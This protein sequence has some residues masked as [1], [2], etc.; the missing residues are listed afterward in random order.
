[1]L[2]P[3][4][5]AAQAPVTGP[6]A[7]A[8]LPPK[9]VTPPCAD[10]MVLAGN[11]CMDRYEA[12]VVEVD[13]AGHEKPHSPYEVIGRA[14]VKAKNAEGHVPQAYISQLQ[15][16]AACEEAGK[17]LCSAEEFTFA[18]SGGDPSSNDYPYGGHEHKDGYCNEG[19]G[20]MMYRLY[21][22]DPRA[23]TSANFNDPRLNQVEGGLAKSGQYPRCVSAFGV[24]DCVGNLHEWGS[25]PP[26]AMGLGRFRGGFYGD[27]EVNGH[28]C[29][30]VTRAHGPSY[31]DYS[32]GFRCCA[33]AKG[34]EWA[35]GAS[36]TKAGGRANRTAAP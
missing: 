6:N 16:R 30:Y 25:D 18:C 13:E 4:A 11:V 14:R 9:P 24:H 1:V 8:V 28:G 29:K 22:S 15:S 5:C 23:W 26:D 17:R 2:V 33:D 21:G 27:A 10:D 12:F 3:L 35:A 20:S 31:H 34:V 32:T 7:W 19:K 36:T